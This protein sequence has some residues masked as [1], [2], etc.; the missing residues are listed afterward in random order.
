MGNATR[1]E[2]STCTQTSLFV[3]VI[4][5][6]FVGY[7]QPFNAGHVNPRR[8]VEAQQKVAAGNLCRVIDDSVRDVHRRGGGG[9]GGDN[10]G[11]FLLYFD[12]L[13]EEILAGKVV[14]APGAYVNFVPF[15]QV[16]GLFL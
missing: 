16:S 14:L 4:G 8:F 2:C 10:G 3:V 15:L 11:G 1:W 5:R 12:G 7:W 9:D 6:G 13:S